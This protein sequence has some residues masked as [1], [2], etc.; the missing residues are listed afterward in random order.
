MAT[1][2]QPV[3]M[4]AEEFLALPDDDM[5]RMLIEGRLWE[6]PMTRRNRWQSRIEARVAGL[7]DRWLSMR[8]K[9]WG[10]I[11]S[12]EAAFRISPETVVGIDV[13]YASAEI[14]ARDP[15][16]TRVVDGPPLLAVEILSPSDTLEEITAKVESY[17]KANVPLVWI[18][19]PH[20]QTVTVYRPEG[21]P[22][23]LYGDDELIGDPH[24]PGFRVRAS[25][26]FTRD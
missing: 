18:I 24:L 6:K 15:E 13:A 9:P 3:L 20:F 21:R 23:L 12:G 16:D 26:V 10:E 19:D 14:A 5:D 1:A 17:L 25:Q 8:P 22:E 4:T 7:L 2:T 11:F